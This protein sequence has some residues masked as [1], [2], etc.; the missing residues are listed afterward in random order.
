MM[1]VGFGDITPANSKEVVIVSFL[2]M[3]SCIILGYNISEIGHLI[4]LLREKN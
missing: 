4:S 3:S 2:E 1:T